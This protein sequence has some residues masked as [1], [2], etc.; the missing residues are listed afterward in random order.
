LRGAF[1]FPI[2]HGVKT[3]GV[4]EFYSAAVREPDSDFLEMVSTL[5]NQ[6]GL[7][8]ERRRAEDSLRESEQRFARF[9]HHLPGLA[10]IKDLHGRYV[11]AN[12]AAQKAFRAHGEQLYGKTDDDVFPPATPAVFKANDERV[13][14]TRSDVQVI[15]TLAHED[16]ALRHSIVSKF[17]INGPDGQPALVAGMAIDITDRL[18]AEESLKMA[19]R[20]KDEFLAMLAHELR[21]PLAPIQNALQIMKLAE[22]NI[23]T[24]RQARAMIERQF[25]H[26]VRLVD[27]LLDVSRIVRN[28]IELRKEPIDLASILTHGIET[29]QPVI[30]T[31]GHQLQVEWPP[32][33]IHVEGD[34]VRLAQVVSNLLVNAAKYTDRAGR[35]FL[36]GAREDTS[37]VVRVRDTGVGIDPALLPHIFDLFTQS[38]RS[39][40][41][42]QGGLGIGLTLVKRLVELHGGSVSA[43]S[44]GPGKG[45]EFVI[46]LPAIPAFTAAASGTPAETIGSSRSIHRILVVDDNVDAGESTAMVLRLRGHEVAT[47]HDGPSALDAVREFNPGIVLLDIGLPG[48]SG[49]DAARHLRA[50]PKYQSLVLIAITGYGQPRDRQQT[51]EAGFDRHLVKPVDQQAL[52]DLLDTV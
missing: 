22:T 43:L 10:W 16:G 50:Q 48:M 17:P 21:N 1:G 23:D 5:G 36:S 11:F 45:C 47:A 30:D 29:A 27:D 52:A 14:L 31:Q 32:A 40:A 7:F 28:R 35:I 46:R 13:L 37:A 9:M 34:P 44:D 19:D 3:L 49:Y 51:Q 33:P 8:V 39:L 2:L 42:S 38:D 25:T 41:R 6:I 24:V 4:I 26:L 20:Q 15:E 12:D 18:R